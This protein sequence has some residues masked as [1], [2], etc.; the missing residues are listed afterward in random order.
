M[1]TFTVYTGKAFATP[2]HGH[3][4]ARALDMGWQRASL[5]PVLAS[6]LLCPGTTSNIGPPSAAAQPEAPLL[7]SPLHRH[8]QKAGKKKK[9]TTIREEAE[10]PLNCTPSNLAAGALEHGGRGNNNM[11]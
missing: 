2:P 11:R 10:M 6:A 9:Q 5:L 1:Q 4:S 8:T 7:S 3:L